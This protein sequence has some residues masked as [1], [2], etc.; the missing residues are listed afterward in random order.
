MLN[1]IQ[2]F[3]VLG[4][5][6]YGSRALGECTKHFGCR[7]QGLGVQGVGLI[8]ILGVRAVKDM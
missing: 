8:L 5:K 7:T 4:Q 3:W 1:M 2:G 6:T